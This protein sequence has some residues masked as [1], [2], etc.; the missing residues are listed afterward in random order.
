MERIENVWKLMNDWYVAISARAA[1]DFAHSEGAQE[2]VDMY[3]YE[4][5]K[6]IIDLLCSKTQ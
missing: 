6:E 2:V 1:A 4:K 5:E 3:I